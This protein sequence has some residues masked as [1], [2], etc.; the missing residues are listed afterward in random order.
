MTD[1]TRQQISATQ[2]TF[3]IILFEI[4]STPLFFFGSKVGQ[5]AWLAMLMGAVIGLLLLCLFLWIQSKEPERDLIQILNVYFGR[6]I[7]S[8][9]GA[10]YF[11]YF[12]YE[13]MRNVRDFG[14]LISVTILS[15]T[16]IVV[17]MLIVILIAA[18]GVYQ[19]VEVFFR[20]A[21]IL[22]PV[23]LVSYGILFLLLFLGDLVHFERLG[24]V[25]ENGLLPILKASF[26]DIVS[27]PFGQMIVFL[28]FWQMVR[29][30]KVVVKTSV[31]AYVL[32]AI[33]LVFVN[34]LN[35]VILGPTL[36]GMAAL[37]LLQASQL[38]SVADVFERV[39]VFVTLL[40]YVGLFIKMSAFYY[41][42]VQALSH[43]T[44]KRYK[45]WVLP[46][47][48]VIFA[49]A[50]LEPNYTY[51]ISLGLTTSL[52]VFP[53]FQIAIPLL[54]SAVMLIRISLKRNTKS[55]SA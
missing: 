24:P 40:I 30:K 49:V 51:H 38:I 32:V 50:L 12:G 29:E 46:T 26:P 33:F 36:A 52:K 5:D 43:L 10:S 42:A 31:L 34:I 47:G 13:S 16:P 44:G 20:I 19:G 41:C 15:Q 25:M 21:E 9:F 4:G 35:L 14:E 17:I 39:D 3:V 6:F 11:V 55:G 22:L 45:L 23:I 27:F 28:M 2:L 37:P 48:A 53:I 18:Y 8:I 54:L 1:G 7:G